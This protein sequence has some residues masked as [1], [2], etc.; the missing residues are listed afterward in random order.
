MFS[1]L[2]VPTLVFIIYLPPNY[3]ILGFKVLI[4]GR[5]TL[6]YDQT[7]V[8][9]PMDIICLT[10]N[11]FL[12]GLSFV[13]TLNLNRAWLRSSIP[14]LASRSPRCCACGS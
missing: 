7:V 1:Y 5:P 2:L 6:G 3:L 12:A 9:D 14:E 10:S 11:A 13:W 8:I 4:V